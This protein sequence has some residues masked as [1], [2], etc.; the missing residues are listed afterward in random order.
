MS[1]TMAI[2]A[3]ALSLQ[4]AIVSRLSAIEELAGV[5]VLCSDKTG[6][7]T[8]NQLT[9]AERH[10]VRLVQAPTTCCST[11][12]WRRQKSSEDA[13]DVAVLAALPARG[14]RSTIK[15]TDFV[16]FDPV[17]K[18]TVGDRRRCRGQDAALRQGRAA[19]DHGAGA[20]RMSTALQRYQNDS[21]R[22]RRQR[23]SRAGRRPVG[24]RQDLELVG[25]ISL[26]DPPRPDAKATIAE[27]QG[28]RAVNVKMVTGDDV[29]IGDRDRRAARYRRSSSRR[30][31]RV[32]RRRR[33]PAL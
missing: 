27:A 30:Q 28:A 25:L 22:A 29:A 4:K 10:S 16:P 20:S 31:R 17:N 7:L 9:V 33:K 6:T 5:D 24:R 13:I 23:L 12:R 3:Y 18:R 11:L 15:Q 19:G 26:M 8:M 1:V 21:R 32:Q 2:G 14:C